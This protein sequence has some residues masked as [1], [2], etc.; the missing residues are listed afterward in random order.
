[1]AHAADGADGVCERRVHPDD[2]GSGA[3]FTTEG[4]LDAGGPQEG[5]RPAQTAG[6]RRGFLGQP[7]PY[8]EMPS[9]LRSA[10]ARRRSAALPI[11]ELRSAMIS[12]TQAA[13]GSASMMLSMPALRF[14]A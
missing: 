2:P 6:E 14:A 8:L 1:V 13:T 7:A 11:H 9:L 5:L 10:P 12:R 3:A 4:H